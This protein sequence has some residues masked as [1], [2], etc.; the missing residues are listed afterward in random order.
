GSLNALVFNLISSLPFFVDVAFDLKIIFHALFVVLFLALLYFGAG[1]IFVAAFHSLK[2]LSIS[3]ELCVSVALTLGTVALL[4]DTFTDYEALS[5]STSAQ[6]LIFLLFV[7]TLDRFLEASFLAE[8]ESFVRFAPVQLSAKVRAFRP[9]D[10]PAPGVNRQLAFVDTDAVE[11]QEESVAVEALQPGDV[12]RVGSREVIPCD[13]VVLRGTCELR[14]IKLSGLA[15]FRL[16]DPGAQ[17]FAGSTVISGEIDCRAESTA[18]D[19]RITSFAGELNLIA[20]KSEGEQQ[21]WS[22]LEGV[23]GAVLLVLALSAGLFWYWQGSAW[24]DAVNISAALLLM[25]L[26]PR[27]VRLLPLTKSVAIVSAFKKGSFLRD[28]T[29]I[30]RLAESRNF[31]IDYA[32]DAPP[33]R[34]RAV[35]FELLDERISEPAL[36]STL[37]SLLSGSDQEFDEAAVAYLRGMVANPHRLEVSDVHVFAGRGIAG[38]VEGT[39]FSMGTEE[40]LLER[41]VQFQSSE[42]EQ[43]GRYESIT[44]VALEDEVVARLRYTPRFLHDGSEMVKRL[45]RLGIRVVLC[46]SGDWEE[47]DAIGKACGLEQVDIKGG[48][49][50]SE[51]EKRLTALGEFVFYSNGGFKLDPKGGSALTMRVFD[52]LAWDVKRSDITLFSSDLSLVANLYELSRRYSAVRRVNFVLTAVLV[53]CLLLLAAGG[54][55]SSLLMA[56]CVLIGALLMQMNVW[57]LAQD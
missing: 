7:L 8:A 57:R 15:G 45:K 9:Q 18:E 20:Q 28:H 51:Y 21:R 46:S 43:P 42:L 11:L 38:I 41:G 34:V 26:A 22:F 56:V 5:Q 37:L 40:F 44:Y 47:L 12:F 35:G 23:L 2:A 10:V 54:F 53:P 32:F 16:K 4:W 55:L 31:V 49:S 30:D 6:S 14:E 50:P 1:S 36:V 39:E 25:S 27:L 33:G 48:L 19:S 24:E 29:A 17:V 52:E 3:K 13:G